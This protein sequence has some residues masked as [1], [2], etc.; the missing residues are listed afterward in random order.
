MAILD[1]T[2]WLGTDYVDLFIFL[3]SG[4]FIAALVAGYFKIFKKEKSDSLTFKLILRTLALFL[5]ISWIGLSVGSN[6]KSGVPVEG[7][8]VNIILTLIIS[9]TLILII[10]NN[11]TK[12]LKAEIEKLNKVAAVVA[13]GDLRTPEFFKN[14]SSND[15]FY[16]FYLSF[17]KMLEQLRNL[18]RSVL[19]ASEQVAGNAEEIA[20]SSSEVSTSSG[21]ISSIMENISHGSQRQVEK[22]ED[23]V[24]AE[25]SL[26]LII[27]ESFEQI[28]ESL[29]LVQEISEE[30]NLLALN[31]S[32]E[33]QRAGDAGRGFGIVANNV[34]R[35]SDD[36]RTYNDS[37]GELLFEVENKIKASQQNIS[38]SIGQIRGV[39]EDVA[40]SSEEVSASAE[41]QAATLEEMSA[42][43]QQLANLSMQLEETLRNFKIE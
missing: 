11:F 40:A 13:K 34:R 21:S 15:I 19:Q 37:I 42:A 2:S 28:Y 5:P 25:K 4:A 12:V 33:A 9:L 31:A 39:S 22:V 8:V 1:E 16:P 43:T 32:I 29:E 7:G 38:R 17:A 10:T 23:A 24:K 35:L 18:I 14:T 20:A 6:M 3:A 30:T 41:E 26:Q 27:E 36:T